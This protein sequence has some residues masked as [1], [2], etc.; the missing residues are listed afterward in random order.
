AAKH[1]YDV[2]GP[3]TVTLGE[4]VDLIAKALGRR[5]V[6]KLQAPSGVVRA[7]MRA[8]HA[9][10]YFPLTPDQLLMLEEDN[11]CDPAPFFSAFELAPDQRRRVDAAAR[12]AG[13]ETQGLLAVQVVLAKELP[14]YWQR[15][16][17]SRVAYVGGEPASGGER[18]G[19]LGRLFGRG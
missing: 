13:D 17:A 14:D 10:P 12:A 16:E 1:A 15:F 7:A 2:G 6:L 5:R 11:V 8:L 18:S 3:D 19:L 9:L 4:L